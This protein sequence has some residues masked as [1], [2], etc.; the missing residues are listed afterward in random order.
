MNS[1]RRAK[2]RT[3]ATDFLQG[4]LLP[5]EAAWALVAFEGEAPDDLRRFLT[6]MVGV[7][8]ETDD[9]PLG[10]RRELWHP[11]VRPTE[12]QKHDEAQVWAEPLV[13]EACK[14]L[15]EAL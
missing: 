7:T 2:L 11:D 3:I 10:H 15:F 8:S 5:L 12:D 4:R 1:A 6:P 14:R 13:R 9:I